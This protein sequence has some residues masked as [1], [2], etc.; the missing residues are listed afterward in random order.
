[1]AGDGNSPTF[2]SSWGQLGYN[3]R[4]LTFPCGASVELQPTNTVCPR[5]TERGPLGSVTGCAIV[6]HS[7]SSWGQ[8]GKTQVQRTPPWA[9]SNKLHP[10]EAKSAACEVVRLGSVT[11]EVA[12]T[13][14][15]SLRTGVSYDTR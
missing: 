13:H 10:V 9:T 2:L 1:M 3:R 4:Q 7:P 8:L 11:G 6:T 5:L 15:L 14:P 12:V